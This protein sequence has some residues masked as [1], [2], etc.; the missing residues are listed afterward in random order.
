MYIPT[1]FLSSKMA[2]SR[3]SLDSTSLQESNPFLLPQSSL[4]PSLC[5][6]TIPPRLSD[7]LQ[8]NAIEKYINMSSSSAHSFFGAIA[9]RFQSMTLSGND[10][11]HFSCPFGKLQFPFV[12]M[13]S[14]VDNNSPSQ[15]FDQGGSQPIRGHRGVYL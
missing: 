11:Q 2:N 1:K 14:A 4:M 15:L 12:P 5:L 13:G 10:Y 9:P 3:D 7:L 8:M 6:D